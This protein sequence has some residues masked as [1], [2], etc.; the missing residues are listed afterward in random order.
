MFEKTESFSIGVWVKP[1]KKDDYAEI[2]GNAGTKNPY[3][4]GYEVFLDSVNRIS[5]RLTHALPHN[6]IQ[7]TTTDAIRLNEWSHF[8]FT[9]D[10]SGKASGLNLYLNGVR[11]NTLSN[12]PDVFGPAAST[13]FTLGVNF[14]DT[15]D[16]GLSD[17]LKLY[18][19]ALAQESVTELFDEG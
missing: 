6:Y 19:E 8:M 12:F 4:R 15:P 18:D 7:V 16:N 13:Q 2:L 14:W 9:Y 17:E 1:A 5:I 3:W 11:V 10:G